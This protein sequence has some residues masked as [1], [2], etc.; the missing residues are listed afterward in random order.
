MTVNELFSNPP[1]LHQKAGRPTHYGLSEAILRELERRLPRGARTLET[2]AGVSTLFFALHGWQHIAIAPDEGLF[3]RIREWCA[4]NGVS[5]DGLRLI[6]E[7]SE[8]CLPTLQCETLDA[9][10]IDG[11]HGFAAPFIDWHYID[12]LLKIGGLLIVDD[13]HLW[14]GRVLRDFLKED[15]AWEYLDEKDLKTALFRKLAD[16]SSTREWRDQPYVFART[17]A[18]SPARNALRLAMAGR[19]AE[20]GQK[21]RKRL[22]AQATA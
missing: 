19:W 2:G 18:M 16:G 12:P 21:A 8:R 22:R 17:P 4:A 1:E 5:A 7:P 15:A 3:E 6:A 11:R 9:V 14:T 20:L 10:L 13:T